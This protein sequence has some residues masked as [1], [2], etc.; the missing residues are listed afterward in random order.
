MAISTQPYKGARD[1]YPEDKRLQKWMFAV[2]RSVCESFGYEEYDAPILEPTDLY[3]SKGS[4]EIVNEQTYSFTDRGGREVTIRTEM[5]PT[6]ARLVAGRA[7]E[8]SYPLRWYS[9]PNLWRYERTQRGRGREFYQLNVDMFGVDNVMADFEMIQIANA[10]LSK[11]GAKKSMYTTIVNSRSLINAIF[12]NYLGLDS[13]QTLKLIRLID[14]M[15]KMTPEVFKNQVQELMSTEQKNTGVY[16]KFMLTMQAKT[17]NDLPEQLQKLPTV[18]EMKKLFGLLDSVG[19]SNYVFDISLM[20]GF[21][22]YTDIVF[23]VMDTNPDNNRSMFGG[24]R[25]DQLVTIFGI[26]PIPVV[27]FAMGDITLQNFLESNNLTPKLANEIDVYALPLSEQMVKIQKLVGELRAEGLNVFLDTSLRKIDKMI[28]SAE[29]KSCQWVLF[30]GDE[31]I[32]SATYKLKNIA[33]GEQMSLSFER[34]VTHLL[35]K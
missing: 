16:D 28:K 17:L 15:K 1:F 34:L 22:Y 33:T 7:Q 24:G 3:K 21:D 32:H 20:R 14:K 18:L 10:I 4:D 13:D 19:I 29:K 6:V 23:E 9:I 8:L 27:G 30:L 2:M 12:N 26:P 31:E 25:Y 11:F 35:A 5:T